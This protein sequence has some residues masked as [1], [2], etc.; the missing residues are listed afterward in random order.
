MAKKAKPEPVKFRLYHE[1]YVLIGFTSTSC[2]PPKAQ[3][4]FC[5]EKLANSSIKPAH[6]Q[7][8]LNGCHVGKPLDFF[9]RKL[10]EF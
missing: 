7:R 4:F 5:G 9:K 8:H 1:D 6:L 2:N 3:C 10:S